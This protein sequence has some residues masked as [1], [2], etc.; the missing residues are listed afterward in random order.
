M[1]VS[2]LILSECQKMYQDQC[3]AQQPNSMHPQIVLQILVGIAVNTNKNI[4]CSAIHILRSHKGKVHRVRKR[5]SFS[6]ST[7]KTCVRQCRYRCVFIVVYYA[8]IF[9]TNIGKCL[10]EYENCRHR[11]LCICS[12]NFLCA[13]RISLY[14]TNCK[15]KIRFWSHTEYKRGHLNAGCFPYPRRSFL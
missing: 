8:Q 11:D 15:M 2:P 3:Q 13:H 4:L 9:L 7:K 6:T 5:E 10:C 1:K 12:M 14:G